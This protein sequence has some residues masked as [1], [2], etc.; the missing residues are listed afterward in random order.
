MQHQG[1][2]KILDCQ[3]YGRE[4]EEDGQFKF[5][6]KKQQINIPI[7]LILKHPQ[8]KIETETLLPNSNQSH[9]LNPKIQTKHKAYPLKIRQHRS[10]HIGAASRPVH[11]YN[12]SPG[13][14]QKQEQ[15]FDR[16]NILP[17]QNHLK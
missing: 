14:D 11:H 12:S 9:H 3:I 8:V 2:E 15:P 17:Q 1:E 7:E 10:R 4:D 13:L 6:Q 5:Y 16:Q